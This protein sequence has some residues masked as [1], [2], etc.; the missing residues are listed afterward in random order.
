M[1]D[2]SPFAF[3]AET[4][5]RIED[6]IVSTLDDRATS[7]GDADWEGRLGQF[8]RSSRVRAPG[9]ARNR[10]AADPDAWA[11]FRVASGR[12]M[13]VVALTDEA[14]VREGDL[15]ELVDDL[16]AL[17]DA[18]H[19]RIVLDFA[20][21]ERL[22]IGAAAALAG[23]ARRC[24][25]S[26]GL[27][28]F[29]GLRPDVASAFGLAGLAPFAE[30]CP[31]AASAIAGAWPRSNPWKPLPV[32]VLSALTR[33]CRRGASGRPSSSPS[34]EGC[35]AMMT[36]RLVA[37]TE[38]ERGRAVAFDGRRL[39]IGRASD[40]RL[41][42][43]FATV[44][45]HHAVIERRGG[46]LRVRDLG[47][48]NGSALN[49]RPL[50]GES[51]EI[52]DGDRLQFG[53]MVFRVEVATPTAASAGEVDGWIRGFDAEDP[54]LPTGFFAASNGTPTLPES[55]IILDGDSLA[56]FGLKAEVLDDV[57]VVAPQSP[58]LDDEAAVDGLRDGLDA[59]FE[60]AGSHRIVVD[61]VHVGRISGRAIGV[62]LAY[63][64][65]LDRAGGALRVCRAHPR[66]AAVLDAVRLG[67][68][69]ELHPTVEAAVLS[70]WPST[71][72]ASGWV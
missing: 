49:G 31:D 66:V 23:P 11:R 10:V 45:R 32:P 7:A 50:R 40:C 1:T 61:L 34:A 52:R 58:S 2:S 19:H 24:G 16:F 56:E 4:A 37:E 57:V 17:I 21:V 28:K 26:G 41:R 65:R 72:S 25:E 9:P 47:S 68:L 43:G 67:M 29:S 42:L 15:A 30:V 60:A 70:A 64:L 6:W 59:L 12:G 18:G 39:V 22:T 55:S 38:P 48:T 33:S 35:P 20:R 53:P 14:L 44:S 3:D 46:L 36:A 8:L 69:V 51:A 13:T 62:L 63:H 54:S 27:L 5:R 71:G